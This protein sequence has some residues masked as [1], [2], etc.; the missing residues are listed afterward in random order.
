MSVIARDVAP[1]VGMP[2]RGVPARVAAGGTH[3]LPT[4]SFGKRRFIATVYA[5]CL[6]IL[7]LCATPKAC[8]QASAAPEWDRLFQNTNG[9]I[10]AD[11]NYSVPLGNDR[12]LWLFSDT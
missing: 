10:G 6:L 9:W 4:R 7:F 2:R 8:G 12:V 11:G 1:G 3:R 5:L